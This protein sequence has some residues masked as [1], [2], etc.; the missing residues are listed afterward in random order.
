MPGEEIL[1]VVDKDAS[2]APNKLAPTVQLY[3]K[4]PSSPITLLLSK[5]IAPSESHITVLFDTA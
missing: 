5:D 4:T 2:G 3:V 1:C